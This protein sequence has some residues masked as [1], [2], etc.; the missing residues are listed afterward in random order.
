MEL[1]WLSLGAT[2]SLTGKE[3]EVKP[4]GF[5]RAPPGGKVK[6]AQKAPE[7]WMGRMEGQHP[8]VQ[9][10]SFSCTRWGIKPGYTAF[11]S[12]ASGWKR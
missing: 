3:K 9:G 10:V 11:L 5:Q 7:G 12:L 4:L 2:G 8:K 6:N 1:D